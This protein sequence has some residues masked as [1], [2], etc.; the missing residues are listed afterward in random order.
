MQPRDCALVTG[1]SRGIGAA[2]CKAIGEAELGIVVNYAKN[3]SSARKVIDELKA[4]GIEACACQANIART[5]ERS[6]LLKESL[7][8]FGRIRVLVNNAGMAPRTRK[9][10][11]EASEESYDEVMGVNLKGPHFLTAAVSQLML[12]WLKEDS[13][14]EPRIIFIGSVSAYA[15][16]VKRPEYCISKAGMS[17]S[18]ALFA[19]RLASHGIP[20]YEVR[21][22]LILTDMTRPV[23]S[24]YDVLIEQ[25]FVPQGRWGT[26]QDVGRAVSMLV[27]GALPFSTGQIID[28]DGGFHLRRL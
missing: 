22:G 19:D 28:V 13:T 4:L 14:F 21:P 1:G 17:M 12:E 3:A 5:E 10:L 7:E 25:G 24:K 20:V 27:R 23:R 2:I 9:D 16:S 6:K 11:L 26:P 15:T 8:R 18:C